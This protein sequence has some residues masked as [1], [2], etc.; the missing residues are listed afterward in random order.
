M[1]RLLCSIPKEQAALGVLP[2]DLVKAL[3]DATPEQL[4]EFADA[5]ACLKA[6]LW[7]LDDQDDAPRSSRW[8]AATPQHRVTGRSRPEALRALAEA[9]KSAKGA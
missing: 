2:D 6:G 3:S 5:A 7:A 9:L 4:Q 8:L 1:P